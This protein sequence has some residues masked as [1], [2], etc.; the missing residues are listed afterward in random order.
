M[1]TALVIRIGTW[2]LSR[3]Y[4]DAKS[5][6]YGQAR[7]SCVPRVRDAYHW[8][9]ENAARHFAETLAR[10]EMRGAKIFLERWHYSE[11][12]NDAQSQVIVTN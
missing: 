3:D 1:K 11:G 8:N 2:F 4:F 10:N 6:F 5:P 9:T 12:D 7:N